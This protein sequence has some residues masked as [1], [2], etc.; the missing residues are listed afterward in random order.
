[1]DAIENLK[2]EVGQETISELAARG[3]R[4]VSTQEVLAQ[5]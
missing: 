4:L 1:V 3:A 2:K 5:I